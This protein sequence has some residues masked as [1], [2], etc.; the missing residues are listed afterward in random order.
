MSEHG[1]A[2][3]VLD[4]AEPDDLHATRET[5]VEAIDYPG[6]RL[7]A[8][9]A[10]GVNN[11]PVDF[12]FRHGR[13]LRRE[14]RMTDAGP[15]DVLVTAFD[16][17]RYPDNRVAL[18]AVKTH[19]PHPDAH[20]PLA[21]ADAVFW[22]DAAVQKFVFPYVASCSGEGAREGLDKL[23]LAWNHYPEHRVS[24]YGLVHVNHFRAHTELRL[25]DAFLVAFARRH[26]RE[27]DP[28]IELLTVSEFIDEFKPK[29]SP[30]P[31]PRKVH[32]HRGAGGAEPQRP[33]YVALR[34]LAEWAC[35]IRGEPRYFVFPA[36][37][38]GFHGPFP[39]LPAV[40]P[41]DIVIPV[42]TPTVPA[43][44]PELGALWFTPAR[45]SGQKP[46]HARNLAGQ[47][48][49]LFWSTG[50]VE[51]F[52]FPYYASKAGLKSLPQLVEMA[53]AWTGHLPE[54]VVPEGPAWK[55]VSPLAEAQGG[56]TVT[57]LIHLHTSEWTDVNEEGAVQ[58]ATDVE[59]EVGADGS[60]EVSAQEAVEGAA[61]GVRHLDLRR[62]IGVVTVNE[63][64]HTR[65]QRLDRFM[66]RRPA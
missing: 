58:S 46:A 62:Q 12:I 21:R 51:Q 33:D 7:L 60:V 17:G 54:G 28:P 37:G 61:R 15:A 2:T 66:A 29:R 27:E 32:Y 25:E 9:C 55:A 42:H 1:F 43:N 8:E 49:A 38:N 50:A 22:S 57:A 18:D 65:V 52:L 6:L 41:G 44:R 47:G 63:H 40:Q 3:E 19:H 31:E 13:S 64:G 10:A 59:I 24:V 23:Q 4:P 14:P 16:G 11:E 39:W 36:G 20:P 26:A 48:D 30:A 56:A 35:S 5:R 34:A 53:Y 45:E